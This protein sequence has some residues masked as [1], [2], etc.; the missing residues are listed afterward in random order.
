[1]TDPNRRF[2]DV[3]HLQ[4]QLKE[5]SVSGGIWTFAA[6]LTSFLLNVGSLSLLGRLIAPS[7]FG[8]FD[9]V[10]VFAGFALLFS[11]LGLGQA[12]V[13]R[14]SLDQL[15]VSALFWINLLIGV[16]LSTLFALSGRMIADF[17]GE[18]ALLPVC[19]V[20]SVTFTLSAAEVQHK[21]LLIRQMEFGKLSAINVLSQAIGVFVAAIGGALGWA[22]WALVAMQLAVA[23]SRCALTWWMNPWLPSSPKA[24]FHQSDAPSML[25][26]GLH[27]A[28]FNAI[29]YFGR[30]ADNAVIGRFSG[31]EALG[32]YSR[33]Y[34]LLALPLQQLNTPL[35]TVAIPALSRLQTTPAKFA[36]YYYEVVRIVA[37]GTLTMTAVLY[38][39]AESAIVVILGSA[40][41]GAAQLF[42]ILA[43]ASFGQ[44]ISSTGGWLY[45]ATGRSRAMLLFGL[46]TTPVIVLGFVIGALWD[47]ARGVAWS[48]AITSWLFRLPAIYFAT[49]NTQVTL[50][51]TL[52]ASAPAAL[53]AILLGTAA[54][55]VTRATPN[56][57]ALARLSLALSATALMT[58]LLLVVPPLRRDLLQALRVLEPKLN[59]LR[60]KLPF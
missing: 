20:L 25:R 15:T 26:F 14:A 3:D 2:F 6:Q 35:A 11:D 8:T 44:A 22:Y 51:G 10:M 31:N 40:W 55:T 56:L 5:R 32:L 9:M 50:S 24:M 13:Q 47:G 29:N 48:Y 60:R 53:F 39:T 46:C 57:G 45:T 21:A 7:A 30:N 42:K 49:R 37:Y 59:Q 38:A 18:P 1:M 58:A 54:W 23:G 27:L 41:I 4:T 12:T 33:A 34:K 43:I 19:A 52:K 16:S 17:Y 28:G 36:S